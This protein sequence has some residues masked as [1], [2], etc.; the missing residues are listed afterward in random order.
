LHRLTERTSRA[1]CGRRDILSLIHFNRDSNMYRLKSTGN[2]SGF[3]LALGFLVTCVPSF[4]EVQPESLQTGRVL[5]A[6]VRL[7]RS[8]RK[9]NRRSDWSSACVR[10]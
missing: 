3:L 4:A 7:G 9:L 8:E 1:N 2:W 5:L 6:R 10:A